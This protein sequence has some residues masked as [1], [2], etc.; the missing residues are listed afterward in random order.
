M[1]WRW[2]QQQY[3][4]QQVGMRIYSSSHSKDQAVV[5][6]CS[7]IVYLLVP[8]TWYIV[9]V[10]VKST[11]S[12]HKAVLEHLNEVDHRFEWFNKAIK[13]QSQQVSTA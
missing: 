3:S 5:V 2:A 10:R 4:Q 1:C 11:G 12:K 9:R 7:E 6:S 13:S 8:G